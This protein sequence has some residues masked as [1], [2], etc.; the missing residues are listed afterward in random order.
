MKNRKKTTKKKTAKRSKKAPA[1]S[2][3]GRYPISITEVRRL[4]YECEDLVS[5]DAEARTSRPLAS[6]LKRYSRL[7]AA[8][9]RGQFLRNLKALAGVV[10]TVSEAAHKLGL[11]SGEAL[12]DMIDCDAE[13]G[14]IWRQKRLNTIIEARAALLESAKEGNQTAIRAVE[15]YLREEKGSAG[16]RADTSRLRQTELCELLSTPRVTINDW[17]A[18][19]GLPR[20]A[21][22]TYNLTEV[23]RW[24]TEFLKRKDAGRIQPADKLRDLKAEE[25]Q[26]QLAERK[27]QLLDREEVIA[28]LVGRW[29]KI[30][31]A[32]RYKKRE[33]ANLVHGQ[34][35]DNI[36]DILGRFFED[37]QR[38]CISVPEFLNLPPAAAEKL[39]ECMEICGA[40]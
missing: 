39:S 33:M 26:L 4:G 32:L 38:E 34:T 8:W 29:Q 30:V 2:E 5:A 13:V 18:R 31:G 9:E 7:A 20:N 37:I 25:K 35:V 22:R 15:N 17:I 10:A 6:I 27:H 3:R 24:Y 21:D 28:G 12:R 11:P 40:D 16:A 14:D 23:L 19:Q 1:A 36:E